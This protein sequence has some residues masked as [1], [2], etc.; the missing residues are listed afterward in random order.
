MKTAHSKHIDSKVSATNMG[1]AYVVLLGMA[2]VSI[3]IITDY[4]NHTPVV[5]KFAPLAI[6]ILTT[7]AITLINRYNYRPPRRTQ[8]FFRRL[9]KPLFITMLAILAIMFWI[10]LA[11]QPPFPPGTSACPGSNHFPSNWND[12]MFCDH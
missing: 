3:S 1:N 10:D 4:V 2:I 11:Q 6:T 9:L 7:A 12:H 8:R 5:W